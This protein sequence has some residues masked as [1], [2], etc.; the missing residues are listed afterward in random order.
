MLLGRPWLKDIKVAHDWGSNIVTIQRNGTTRTITV[1]KHLGGEVKI[2]ELLLCYHYQNC[3]TNEEKDIIFATKPKKISIGI[4]NLPK[5]IQ[6][7]KTT[8]VEIMDINGKTNTTKL[9]YGVY[10]EHRKKTT[11]NI[12]KPKVALEDK[13]YPKMYYSH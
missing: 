8:N 7:M 10:I 4:I 12:Y 1:T 11:S 9:N 5:T 3:I 6:S 2:L 13:V